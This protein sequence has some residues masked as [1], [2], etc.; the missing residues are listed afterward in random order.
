MLEISFDLDVRQATAE[1]SDWAQRRVPSITR[2]ALN[3]TAFDARAAEQ[4]KIRGVFDRP[5]PWIV[6]SVKVSKATKEDLVAE[7]LIA[8]DVNGSGVSPRKVLEAEVAG[9]QRRHKRFEMALIRAGVMHPDEYALPAM[10]QRRDA[11]GNLPGTLIVRILSQLKAFS[12]VGFLM[13]RTQ[14]SKAKAASKRAAQYFVPTEGGGR[15]ARGIGRL[16]RGIYERRGKKIRGVV[17]FIRP[18]RYEKRYDFGQATIAK[19]ERV[20]PAHWQRYFDAEMA[21]RPG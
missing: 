6:R 19:A 16:P 13:N 10:G 9:G 21:K 14:R 2:N 7:V 5:T 3:D 12:E 17:M 11:Y 18:P 15:G 4:N 8:D 1:L 20:F